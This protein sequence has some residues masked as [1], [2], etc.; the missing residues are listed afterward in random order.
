[1]LKTKVLKCITE[2]T[3]L[4]FGQPFYIEGYKTPYRLE[5]TGVVKRFIGETWSDCSWS[6]LDLIVLIDNCKIQRC[7]EALVEADEVWERKKKK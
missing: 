1:M 3:G 2:E 5:K 4:S 6:Y 7:D